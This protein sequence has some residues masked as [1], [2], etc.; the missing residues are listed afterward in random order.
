[1]LDYF[2]PREV[3]ERVTKLCRYDEDQE[4]WTLQGIEMTGNRMRGFV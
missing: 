4:K 1:M 2:V 3:Q